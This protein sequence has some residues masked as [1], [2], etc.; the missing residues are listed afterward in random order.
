M[1]SKPSKEL[2]TALLFAV[3]YS[4]VHLPRSDLFLDEKSLRSYNIIRKITSGTRSKFEDARLQEALAVYDILNGSD[5]E[6]IINLRGDLSPYGVD[7]ATRNPGKVYVDVTNPEIAEYKRKIIQDEFNSIDG[8][9]ILGADPL[10]DDLASKIDNEVGR[11]LK[12]KKTEAYFIGKGAYLNHSQYDQAM[13]N[14][15]RSLDW[16]KGEEI[17][18]L[19]FDDANPH[20]P[21]KPGKR[22]TILIKLVGRS[23][24]NS[25]FDG[26]K[27]K[28]KEYF[29]ELGFF[30]YD[31]LD[32]ILSRYSL[33]TGNHPFN[34]IARVSKASP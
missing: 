18:S 26:D 27:N 17:A 9:Y 28:A 7:W 22:Q 29:R 16:I 12:G 13:Q 14:I 33:L 1:A 24:I 25:H 6:I 3:L 5:S 19:V 30:D 4:K 15:S 10:Y 31:S 20:S 21:N 34:P 8:Y 2:R 23:T 32:G 11:P